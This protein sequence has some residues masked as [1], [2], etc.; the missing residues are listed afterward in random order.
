MSCEFFFHL[1]RNKSVEKIIVP[2]IVQHLGFGG[3]DMKT[4]IVTPGNFTATHEQQAP[5]GDL[6]FIHGM[7][8]AGVLGNYAVV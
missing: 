2:T 8:T 6:L 1:H 7:P 3:P 4:L 5:A